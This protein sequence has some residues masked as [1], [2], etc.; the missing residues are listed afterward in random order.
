[1]KI[2]LI[3]KSYDEVMALPKGK[4][5]TPH[6]PDIFFRTLMKLVALPDMIK[7][8]F[9][10][11]KIGMEKLKR[12]EPALYLMNHSSFIDLSIVATLLYPNPFNIITTTDGFIGKN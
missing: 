7:T 2:K 6:K 3:E 5:I 12:G 8:G 10:S 4:H 11:E 9:K 1:M